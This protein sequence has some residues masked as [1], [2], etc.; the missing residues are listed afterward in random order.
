MFP[1]DACRPNNHPLCTS[2]QLP[3]Q[4]QSDALLHAFPLQQFDVHKGR[5]QCKRYSRAVQ[6][7]HDPVGINSS[8]RTLIIDCPLSHRSGEA[9]GSELRP[10]HLIC[11]TSQRQSSTAARLFRIEI[12]PRSRVGTMSGPLVREDEII[13]KGD[14][15]SRYYYGATMFR[16]AHQHAADRTTPH[17]A[18][19][20]CGPT[21]KGIFWQPFSTNMPQGAR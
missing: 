19:N 17:R 18:L 21:S 1:L 9:E 3:A 12:S 10:E 6:I 2:A 14:P 11:T 16:F 8:P 5:Q 20:Y 15:R 7:L 4:S 13:L